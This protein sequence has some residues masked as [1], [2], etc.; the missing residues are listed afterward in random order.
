[1][2]SFTDAG[3][4]LENIVGF[5]SDG[6]NTMMGK[7]NSVSSRLKSDLP[8]IT[9]QRCVCHSLHLCASEACRQLPRRCEDLARNI[10]GYFKN[11][12][13]R[14]AQLREFQDF[15]HVEPHKM[16]KPSQTRWLSLNDVVK[17]VSAQW[18]AL[19][20]FSQI[21]GLRPDLLL[22]RLF[23]THSMTSLYASSIISLNGSYQ[24]SQIL[25]SIFRVK[26]W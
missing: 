6:C 23:F 5:G 11:S 12:A 22:R 4:P 13:K 8:G 2:K 14:I 16:L 24:N 7:H 21:S 17:R 15:C 25:I 3:V 9:V 26:R 18:D 1:M 20:L 19:R 10:Y